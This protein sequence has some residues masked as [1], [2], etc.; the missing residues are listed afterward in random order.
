VTDTNAFSINSFS[1]IDGPFPLSFQVQR[2]TGGYLSTRAHA[3]RV[4]SLLPI[5]V[6]ASILRLCVFSLDH[7]ELSRDGC[8]VVPLVELARSHGLSSEVIDASTIVLSTASLLALVGDVS[9]YNLYLF[10]VP[11]SWSSSA[12]EDAV[13]AITDTSGGTC[14]L[15]KLPESRFYLSSHDDCYVH[16]ECCE[17]SL[18]AAQLG[19]LLQQYAEALLGHPVARPDIS[20]CRSLLELSLT[21]SSTERL[22]SPAAPERR[23]GLS[24]DSW[25]PNRASELRADIALSVDPT[26]SRWNLVE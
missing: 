2:H 9:H 3:Q 5:A 25:T 12:I 23:I 15:S 7:Y 4:A 21:L 16:I 14:T 19:A 17:E 20:L 11:D 24:K 8:T 18:P 22:C 6:E 1:G 10:H 13:L 26:Y